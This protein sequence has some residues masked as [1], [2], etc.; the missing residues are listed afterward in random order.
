MKTFW[1]KSGTAIRL[2]NEDN[3][4]ILDQLDV[5]VYNLNV[6]LGGYY[7]EETEPFKLPPKFYGKIHKYS[8]RIISTY[9]LRL[10]E[11]R[12]TGVILSG[13]KGSGK[14]L[15]AKK[16]ASEMNLPVIL[17]GAPFSDDPFKDL[18]VQIGKC[19]V[20]FDEFE[21]IYSDMDHQNALLTLFD[22]VFQTQALFIIIMNDKYKL[23]TAMTNRPGRFY[24]M[25]EYLGL[26]QEFIVE[27]CR[28]YNIPEKRINGVKATALQ[29][30]NFNFDM[31]QALVEEMIRYDEDANE[32]LTMLNIK[33]FPS[34][35]EYG[36]TL[37]KNGKEV[38]LDEESK[39]LKNSPLATSYISLYYT[40]NKKNEHVAFQPK[41]FDSI[42][43]AT[44]T[45]IFKRDIYELRYKPL[46]I[47]G[48]RITEDG[49]SKYLTV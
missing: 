23:S 39:T 46:P 32:A 18:I 3:V 4:K 11:N 43:S 21:K 26:D 22:G 17:I 36:A 29:F 35:R 41:D 1:T 34:Y 5:G 27:Y 48:Y 8:E 30:E 49:V 10:Q 25:L 45:I 47:S 15:L 37:F 33:A 42:D 20:I 7:L 31:L 2:A 9:N 44:E 13:E 40:V 19:V 6:D 38:K 14:T 16:L 12:S 24:Y 28:D